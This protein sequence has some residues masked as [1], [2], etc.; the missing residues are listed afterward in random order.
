MTAHLARPLVAPR[1]V[2]EATPRPIAGWR[3]AAFLAPAL[4][5]G[6]LSVPLSLYLPPYLSGPVG[7]GL[8]GVGFA[9]FFVRI[10][11]IVFDPLMG[12][13]LDRTRS[14]WGQCRVWMVSGAAITALM[15]LFLFLAPPGTPLSFVIFGLLGL[16]A[17]ISALTMAQPAWGA[18]LVTNYNDRSKLYAWMHFATLGGTFLI[19]GMPL[20]VNLVRRLA[21]GEDVHL[22]GLGIA[23]FLP[24]LT[25]VMILATKEPAVPI[26][27][28]GVSR[29]VRITDYLILL[30]RPSMTRVIVA[31]GLINIASGTSSAT[32]L[33]FWRSRGVSAS[34]S[35]GLVLIYLAAAVISIPA[36][37]ALA[38]RIEKHRA[39]MISSFG[40]AVIFPLLVVLPTGQPLVL[41]AAIAVAGLVSSPGS[42]LTRAMAADAADDARLHMGVDRTGQVYALFGTTA[43]LG[44]AVAIG[45]SYSVLQAVNFQAN[46]GASN[47][48]MAIRTVQ[49]LHGIFPA[50]VMLAALLLFVGY[51]LGREEHGR[52]LSALAGIDAKS[53]VEASG[54]G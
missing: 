3:L 31:D 38:R 41:M 33:F 32:F 52:V 46:A 30:R 23:I 45:A 19:V 13:F 43:K 44:S 11:D 53:S 47:G 21:P 10:L 28:S 22:M 40:Y 2:S 16:Y 29:P 26:A 51:R 14:R 4:P 54:Q 42:F 8:G 49:F 34:M 18:R 6:A 17:G 5:V 24:V 15:T 1:E 12:V 36:W 20:A 25:A 9:F 48:L 27:H 35:S 39:L 7:L 50:I 37:M